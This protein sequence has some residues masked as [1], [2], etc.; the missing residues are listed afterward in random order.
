[1][2]AEQWQLFATPYYIIAYGQR[3]LRDIYSKGEEPCDLFLLSC[4]VLKTH[5]QKIFGLLNFL[6]SFDKVSTTI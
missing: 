5:G 1:M 3:K 4:I 2:I 6:N